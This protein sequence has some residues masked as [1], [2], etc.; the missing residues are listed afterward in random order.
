MK[1]TTDIAFMF[2]LSLIFISLAIL[3]PML[4]PYGVPQMDMVDF[5][6]IGASLIGVGVSCTLFTGL[7]CVA[8]TIIGS[9]LTFFSIPNEYSIIFIG[10]MFT[11]AYII[12]KLSRGN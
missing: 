6:V 10:F 4:S 2:T 12:A 11:F 8:G 1:G 7:G 3:T 9:T 5:G